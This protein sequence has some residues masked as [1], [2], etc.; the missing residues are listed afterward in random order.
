MHVVDRVLRLAYNLL[1]NNTK[2]YVSGFRT[3]D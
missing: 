2:I 1:D 3:T